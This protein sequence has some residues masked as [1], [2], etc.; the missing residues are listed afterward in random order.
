MNKEEL[1]ALKLDAQLHARDI[2]EQLKAEE[3]P[4]ECPRCQGLRWV[5]D[6]KGNEITCPKCGGTGNLETE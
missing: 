1:E 3:E 5:E 4:E 2:G 6:D